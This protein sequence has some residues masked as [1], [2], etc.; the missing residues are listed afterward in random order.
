MKELIINA[1]NPSL[2]LENVKKYIKK[3][4]KTED[5]NYFIDEITDII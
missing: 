4:L 1:E 2:F 5:H 3:L